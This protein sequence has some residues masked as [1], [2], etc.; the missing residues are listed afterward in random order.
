MN[1]E[2][3]SIQEFQEIFKQEFGE[4]LSY[5]EARGEAENFLNLIRLI[6]KK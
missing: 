2:K 4:E 6:I 3:H 5:S 1:L